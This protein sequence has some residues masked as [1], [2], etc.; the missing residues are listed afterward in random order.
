MIRNIK[1]LFV[2]GIAHCAA[3]APS[4]ALAQWYVN[5]QGF[6]VQ[7]GQAMGNAGPASSMGAGP[8]GQTQPRGVGAINTGGPFGGGSITANSTL[9]GAVSTGNFASGTGGFGNNGFGG[10]GGGS[11]S[12]ALLYG[13]GYGGYGG[14]GG[15]MMD[16][17]SNY[18]SVQYNGMSNLLRAYGSYTV[19][20]SQ[21][22]MNTERART[23]YIDNEQKIWRA[24]QAFKRMKTTQVAEQRETDKA[25]REKREE[26]MDSHRPRPLSQ[27]H[28]DSQNGSLNWPVALKDPQ[29]EE[30][31]TALDEL[32]SQ[33]ARGYDSDRSAAASKINQAV[34]DMRETLRGQILTIPLQD[35]SEARQFLD[36]MAATAK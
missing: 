14:I 20:E 9:N 22:L 29:F 34:Q 16:P 6:G 18:A 26:F 35:Y 7:N 24:R 13:G 10:V 25:T 4:A 23:R 2:L 12:D 1:V 11:V 15:G 27:E 36:S 5:P 32:F 28:F 33:K 17:I 21:A 31:R 8:I 19:D 30:T 3:V